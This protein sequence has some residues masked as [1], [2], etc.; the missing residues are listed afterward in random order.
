MHFCH[1]QANLLEG[2]ARLVDPV[3]A[4]RRMRRVHDLRRRTYEDALR[5]NV[6]I[7]TPDTIAAKLSALQAE[8]GLS[9]ILAELNCGGLIPHDKV[10]NAMR[11]MCEKVM[12][13]FAA[14]RARAAA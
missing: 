14:A 9:G 8:I 10:V 7:G 4:E 11:L 12:P 6:L 3:T 1:E 5:A 13:Q 2:A